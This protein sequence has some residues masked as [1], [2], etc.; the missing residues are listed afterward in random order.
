MS[1]PTK[2]P[3]A[4][5]DRIDSVLAGIIRGLERLRYRRI[6]RV[7]NGM[8]R[9]LDESLLNDLGVLRNGRRQSWEGRARGGAGPGRPCP[10]WRAAPLGVISKE[11]GSGARRWPGSPDRRC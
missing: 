5:G 1:K 10:R 4:S 9:T 11:A 7:T 6:Q 3:T 8:L 2:V